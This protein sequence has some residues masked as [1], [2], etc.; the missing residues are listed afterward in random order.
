MRV[1]ISVSDP[2]DLGEALEWRALEGELVR[3]VDDG[4]GGKALIRLD[5]AIAYRDSRWRYLV[6]APRHQGSD[7][8]SLQAGGKVF[9][10]FTPVPDAEAESSELPATNKLRSGLG[11]I[12]DLSAKP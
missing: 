6:A 4:H 12:G 7:I 8:K 9:S 11:F 2:W 5:E 10:A 3:T 1:V